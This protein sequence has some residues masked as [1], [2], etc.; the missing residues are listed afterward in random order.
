MTSSK[1]KLS[2]DHPSI[3][4]GTEAT[5]LVVNG[6]SHITDAFNK[7]KHAGQYPAGTLLN[8]VVRERSSLLPDLLDATALERFEDLMATSSSKEVLD[9]I[10]YILENTEECDER[11]L[12][13]AI[14]LDRKNDSRVVV[15][16]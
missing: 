11:V 13:P 15:L 2:A 6:Y 16:Y 7:L 12:G 3:V 4:Y 10:W 9:A 14:V 5:K 8:E 1:E